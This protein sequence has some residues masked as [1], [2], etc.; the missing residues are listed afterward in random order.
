MVEHVTGDGM[1]EALSAEGEEQER[2]FA[3]A[4]EKRDE[5]SPSREVEVRSVIEVSNI[6]RQTC[7][8][9]GMNC[10][11]K[12]KRY[13]ISREELL[14][15]V[16][17]VYAKGRRVLLLQS[18]ENNSREYVDFI[19]G[20]LAA[21][22]RKFADLTVILCM[23]NLKH[24][25]Y[26]QLRE[27]GADRYILKF[28]T[29]NPELYKQIKPG[30]SLSERTGCLNHLAELGYEVGTGNIIGLPGQT[31]QD[32][33][34]D[35]LFLAQF[36]L[37]MIS[38]TVFIPGE[39]SDYRAEP[40]GDVDPVLNFMALMRIMRPD[41]LIPATSSLERG[42]K[43]GQYLGLAAGANAVTI[44]DGTP[45][46]LK[47]H[48]PI[49]SVDRFTPNENHIRDIVSQA[50]LLFPQSVTAEPLHK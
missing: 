34:N 35:V 1:Y 26:R 19:A 16:S 27:S 11:S 14:A 6:C 23:G 33:V 47:K 10:R 5:Y 39:D 38:S 28:E 45:A 31:L 15:I 43:G 49:Y 50:G 22:K 21:V 24:A 2:L 13:T 41:V 46:E 32:L 9:C 36:K 29:S 12:R 37:S 3:L 4:R 44:H 40:M 8:Y 7:R 48:F 20:C 42:R 17:N 25:Q 30:A 18:G